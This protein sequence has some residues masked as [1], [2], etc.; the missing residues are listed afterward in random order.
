MK[1][2]LKRNYGKKRSYRKKQLKYYRRPVRPRIQYDAPM[3]V[4]FNLT[5]PVS[6]RTPGWFNFLS[7]ANYPTASGGS[8]IIVYHSLPYA[9]ANVNALVV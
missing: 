8:E 4:T 1:K 6:Y 2:V 5:K 3:K 7:A 9:I